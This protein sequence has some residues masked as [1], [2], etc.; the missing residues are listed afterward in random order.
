MS[1]RTGSMAR[2]PLRV[3]SRTGQMAARVTTAAFIVAPYPRSRAATGTTAAG[4]MARRNSSVGPKARS[5]LADAP[6]RSPRSAPSRVAT[7]S[8]TAKV[9]SVWCVAG[10]SRPLVHRAPRPSTHVVGGGK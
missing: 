4:G 6:R 10:H 5:A 8:A 2:T 1:R 9:D 7:A 3:L